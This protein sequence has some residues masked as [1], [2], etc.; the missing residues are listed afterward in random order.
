MRK[1]MAL[2][3][4]T[5]PSVALFDNVL[6]GLLGSLYKGLDVVSRE[7]VGFIPSVRRDTGA[8]GAAL[9]QAVTF[10]I[11]PVNAGSNIVPAMVVPE[12]TGQTI[13]TD[14]ITMTKARAYEFGYVGEEVLGLN[15]GFGFNQIQADMFAQA[16]RGITN[17]IETDL[18][19]EAINNA[20]RATGTS[21]ATP[22]ATNLTDAGQLQKIL[23]DNGAPPDR[24][25]VINTTTAVNLMG[26]AQLTSV[27][28]SGTSM[29]L[30]D[31]VLLDLAGFGFKKSAKMQTHTKGT[32]AGSTTNAAG[33]A[34]GATVITLAAAGTGT[35]LAG[36]AITFAGDTN[37]YIVISG[38]ADVSNGGTITLAGPGL[39]VAIAAGATAITVLN[40]YLSN[41]GFSSNALA[42]A[43]RP[44]APIPGGDAASET[45]LLTDPRSGLT[46]QVSVYK[47]YHKFRIEVGAVWGVKATKR[48]HIV[49]LLG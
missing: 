29:T 1:H 24:T 25:L 33:Y 26:L 28:D 16:L 2:I 18:A 40:S 6:T 5:L 15:N 17:E 22:F 36:D 44:P 19:V 12:P 47:G 14:T 3:T 49:E 23:D 11:T 21:G 41:I 43:I 4:A 20:S 7:L 34:I 9:N 35:L 31:G 32:A 37:K 39:R 38:D 8:E 13:A 30:R 46:F 48:D 45:M 10:A 42:L 27:A